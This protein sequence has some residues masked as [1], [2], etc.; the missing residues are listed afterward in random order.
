MENN[1]RIKFSSAPDAPGVYLMKD[2]RGKIIYIGKAKSLRSRLISYLGKDLNTKTQAMISKVGDV[3]FKLCESESMALLLEAALVRKHKPKYNT[4]LRDDKSFP[5]VKITNDNF[6]SVLITRKRINDGSRYFG[7]Y[8]SPGLLRKAMKTIRINFPYFIS[9]QMPQEARFDQSIGLAPLKDIGKRE[10]LKR[11]EIISLILEGKVESLVKKLSKKMHDSASKMDFEGAA[12]MRDQISALEAINRSHLGD[13]NPQGLRVLRR[14]LKLRMDP[15]RIEAFDVSNI[16]GKE[17]CGS[18]VSFYSGNPDKANYRRFRIK[19]VNRI[20]D[21]GMLR[22]VVKRRYS[23]LLKYNMSLPDLIIIDGGKGHL[24]AAFDELA[25]L[26]LCI[27]LL[28][29]AKEKENVYIKGRTSPINLDQYPSGLNLI[30]RIRDEAHRFAITYHHL[31][32][33]KRIITS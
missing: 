30:R 13:F 9:K 23:R 8:T 31:L 15:K 25:A 24:Q 5:M 26:G 18:M 32:R 2:S 7:P 11:I 4:A 19:T 17:A 28:S 20:D 16:S 6:P 14:I 1:L 33:K 12:K 27:P 29:I 22:E 10:Y 21:Y 3:E